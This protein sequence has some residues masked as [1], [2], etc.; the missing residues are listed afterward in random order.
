[1]SVNLSLGW[2]YDGGSH[3]FRGIRCPTCMSLTSRMV[4][5]P[6]PFVNCLRPPIHRY[7]GGHV[8]CEGKQILVFILASPLSSCSELLA[9]KSENET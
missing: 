4:D 5:V 8:P 1:M 3:R 7:G 2:G 9:R 6:S